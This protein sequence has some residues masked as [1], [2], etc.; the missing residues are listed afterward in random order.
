MGS[1]FG[2][3][4]EGRSLCRAEK[5]AKR[6]TASESAVTMAMILDMNALLQSRLNI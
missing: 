2:D 6:A 3:V 1:G 5:D 4:A